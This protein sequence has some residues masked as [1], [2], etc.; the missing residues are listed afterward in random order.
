MMCFLDQYP[1]DATVSLLET[2]EYRFEGGR[3][4]TM[5]IP[6]KADIVEET[7][8]ICCQTQDVLIHL[9]ELFHGKN[10]LLVY[11]KLEVIVSGSNRT[12]CNHQHTE[13]WEL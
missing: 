8:M 7:D 9:S 11:R 4:C 1:S 13:M 5:L 12:P 10:G 2:F 3:Y 6:D